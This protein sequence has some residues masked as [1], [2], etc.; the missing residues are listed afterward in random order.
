MNSLLY[1]GNN[2]YVAGIPRRISEDDLRRVFAKYG[3][4]LDIKVIRDPVTKNCKGFSYVLFE[5]VSDATR[6]IENLDN[7]KVFNDWSL[8][9]ERAKRAI[10][11]EPNYQCY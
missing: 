7:V 5:R 11:F 4:I 1:E 9:V 8:K 10:P 3:P 6:A 2:V